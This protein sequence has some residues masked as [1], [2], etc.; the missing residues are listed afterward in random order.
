MNASLT[1]LSHAVTDANSLLEI[2]RPLLQMLHDATGLESTYLTSIDKAAGTQSVQY[3]LNTGAMKIPEGITVPWSDTL[4]KRA[5]DEGISYCKEVD[6]HWPDS[7]AAKALGIKSYASA[8]VRTSDGEVVGTLCAA[9][10]ESVELA[11]SA[12]GALN[13]FSKIVSQHI[14]REIL[15]Q[16]LKEANHELQVSALTDSLTNLPNRR[17]IFDELKRMLGRCARNGSPMLIGVIDLDD[18]KV[19]ND[20]FGHLIGDL[21]L[22]EVS[23]RLSSVVRVTDMVGRLGGD[24]FVFLGHCSTKNFDP[25]DAVE[26]S[27]NRLANVVKGH[28]Q[29]GD[30]TISYGGASIG[31]VAL[32]TGSGDDAESA[33]RKADAAMYEE[34]QRRKLG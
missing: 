26:T 6:V 9:G 28:Y 32:K 24:E 30:I 19:I 33:L 2:A 18:F 11:D 7:A 23:R 15:L 20:T 10:S 13:I 1:D 14:D 21:F 29:L 17:A 22:Q 25:I 16:Q 8:P 3:S 5:L 34:K 4:C 12:Q 31:V 27:H